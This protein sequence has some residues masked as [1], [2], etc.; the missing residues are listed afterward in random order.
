MKLTN[1]D[2]A[3]NFETKIKDVDFILIKHCFCFSNV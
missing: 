3:L 2:S 1:R